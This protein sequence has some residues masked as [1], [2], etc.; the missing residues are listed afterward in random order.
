MTFTILQAKTAGFNSIH[1]RITIVMLK[2]TDN[3]VLNII[4]QLVINNGYKPEIIEDVILKKKLQ[5]HY[6][7]YI[8]PL[9]TEIMFKIK[10]NSLT[11]L[12]RF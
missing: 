1:R 2:D 11:I 3:K 8:Q 9:D 6:N 4:N 12:K 10:V 5:K 7:L